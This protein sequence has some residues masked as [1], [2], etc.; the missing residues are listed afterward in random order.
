[1]TRSLTILRGLAL[2]VGVPAAILFAIGAAVT[3][4]EFR[5]RLRLAPE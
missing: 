4:M 1:M 3:W 5:I 2:Y